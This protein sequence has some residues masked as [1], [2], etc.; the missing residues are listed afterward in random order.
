MSWQI[1]M[2]IECPH[3]FALMRGRANYCR[4]CGQALATAVVSANKSNPTSA[5]VK[6]HVRLARFF[7]VVGIGLLIWGISDGSIDRGVLGA[8]LL[9]LGIAGY[10]QEKKNG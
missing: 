2:L 7:C 5:D 1:F 10:V 3:C 4:R 9:I 6:K 8:F